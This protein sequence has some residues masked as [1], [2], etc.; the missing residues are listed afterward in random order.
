M[1]DLYGFALDHFFEEDNEEFDVKL[2]FRAKR[3]RRG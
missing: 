2:A 1:A 3:F